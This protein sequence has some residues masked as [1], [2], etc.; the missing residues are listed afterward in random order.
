LS[1]IRST[2]AGNR[3]LTSGMKARYPSL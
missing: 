1:Y 3:T 2:H